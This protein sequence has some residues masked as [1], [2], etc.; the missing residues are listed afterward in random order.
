MSRDNDNPPPAPPKSRRRLEQEA[1]QAEAARRRLVER[2]ILDA[3]A[4]GKFDNLPGEGKPLQLEEPN[5]GHEDVW[6]AVRM[7]K[8]ANI[9]TDEM[10]Y[11]RRIDLLRSELPEARSE[12]DVR[13]IARELNGWILKLNTLGTNA[14][15][16]TLTPLNEDRAVEEF[17]QA[18]G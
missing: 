9:T 14:V 1:Q 4:E 3:M 13:R 2:R 5:P 17:L 8:Q 18:R 7:L 16:T 15:P 11:R 10:R 6:W 12:A